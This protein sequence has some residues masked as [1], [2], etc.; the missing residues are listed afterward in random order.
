MTLD[1]AKWRENRENNR[2]EH[3][4][5]GCPEAIIDGNHCRSENFDS[6]VY[7]GKTEEYSRCD[8]ANDHMAY[9]SF[10]LSNS[11]PEAQIFKE[12][13]QYASDQAA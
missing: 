8:N 10:L 9:A 11:P 4:M 6:L 3:S 1:L 7:M 13:N 12:L 2:L 5:A